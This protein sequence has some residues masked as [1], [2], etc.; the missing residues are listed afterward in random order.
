M[1]VVL[2]YMYVYVP[3]Q[4]RPASTQEYSLSVRT[5]RRCFSN[6]K[7]PCYSNIRN[8]LFEHPFQRQGIKAPALA[9]RASF[10]SNVLSMFVGST[11]RAYVLWFEH[12]RRCI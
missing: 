2:Y 5:T 6:T 11:P 8:M 7:A 9:Q 12:P 4:K 3:P 10:G 1:Y